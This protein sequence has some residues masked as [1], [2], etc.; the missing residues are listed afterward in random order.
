MLTPLEEQLRNALARHDSLI[1]VVASDTP[2]NKAWTKAALES[3]TVAR[4]ALAAAREK[5]ASK[6]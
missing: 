2:V 4:D 1:A 6:P 3:I 5:E